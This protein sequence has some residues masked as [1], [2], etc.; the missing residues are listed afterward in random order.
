MK[1]FIVEDDI[2]VIKILE[3]IIQDR[4]LGTII[5]Y[6]DNGIDA[7]EEIK[8]ITP[9]IV[10]VDLLMPGKDGISL[11]KEIKNDISKIQFIMISQVTSKDMIARAYEKG[12]E[13]YVNKPINAVEVETVIKKVKEKIEM[14]RMLKEIKRVFANV[15]VQPPQI[16][17]YYNKEKTNTTD[18]IKS[19]MNKLGILGENGSEDIIEVVD[20]LTNPQND[21]SNYS[22]K[23][24]CSKFTDN[25]KS[26]E[27]RIRR[28][29]TT[30]M[31]NLAN[32]GIEDYMNEVFVEYSNGM[33]NFEQIKKEMD[34]VRGKSNNRGKVNLKKFIQGMAFYC[35][36][37]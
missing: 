31:V 23:E 20:F 2:S 19:V 24:L 10:L 12:V 29:A 11:V 17:N 13:Y 37:K 34:Y 18:K 4:E 3:K 1:I 26:M 16:N 6:C 21:K 30:G 5:G 9:D 8:K 25:P 36:K 32:I 28:A 35:E 33:Y 7:L 14:Q 22:I 15:N 27:Q